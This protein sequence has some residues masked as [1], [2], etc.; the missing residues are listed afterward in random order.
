MQEPIG[1]FFELELNQGAHYY[2]N[3]KKLNFA[4]H[5]ITFFFNQKG[6]KR[7]YL[8]TFICSVVI[9]ALEKNNVDIRYYNI[10]SLLKPSVPK[11]EADEGLLLVDYF[12]LANIDAIDVQYPDNV[13]IDSSQA[14]FKTYKNFKQVVYSPRKFFGIP[15]GA[16]LKTDLGDADYHNL[17]EFQ[18]LSF[19]RY[20]LKR[21]ESGPQPTYSDFR[22]T[23]AKI[24]NTKTQKMSKITQRILSN[25]DYKKIVRQRKNNYAYLQKKLG[26]YNLL[27]LPKEGAPLCYPLL[28]RN[29]KTMKKKL[30]QNQ[31]FVP[32][33]WPNVPDNHKADDYDLFITENL[34]N[35]PIDQRYKKTH[36]E[37]LVNLLLILLS[38]N[39]L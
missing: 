23:S 38:K 13:L 6:F 39:N 17:K 21:I 3:L 26:A 36:M 8:P 27:R 2:P 12:G 7:V 11:I 18:S 19:S 20:L 28:I 10:D 9:E 37:Q 32:T 24:R 16:Y 25:V 31:I 4:R 34:V 29:G 33:Y 22:E 15:D 5:A 35:L 30:I 1:G 14:F